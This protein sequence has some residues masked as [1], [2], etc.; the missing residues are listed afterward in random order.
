MRWYFGYPVL[1]AGL[2][3]GAHTLFPREIDDL[4]IRQADL[5][6]EPVEAPRV[7][8]AADVRREA[9]T[10]TRLAAFSP[11]A[12]LLE[13]ELPP[14]RPGMFDYLAQ[15]FAPGQP[16]PAV[17]LAAAVEPVASASWKSAVVHVA[18]T[19]TGT[20]TARTNTAAQRALLASDVQRELQR[21]GC[22]LGEIDGIWGPGSQRAVMAFME[23]VN[24]LLPVE[25]PDVFMLSLLKA[26]SNSVCGT[27][28]PQG[29]S[30]SAAGRCLP[31]TL[32]AHEDSSEPRLTRG[33]TLATRTQ[34][35]ALEPAGVHAAE[36]DWEATV[37]AEVPSPVGRRPPPLHGR[38]GIGGP[39]PDNALLPSSGRSHTAVMPIASRRLHRTASIEPSLP[40]DIAEDLTG[41]AAHPIEAAVPQRRVAEPVAAPRRQPK[42]RAAERPRPV[43][44]SRPKAWRSNYRQVQH[45]FQHPLGRM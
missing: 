11:G 12:R 29:Q 14:P 21:V 8:V 26:E 36:S 39:K 44:S 19:D 16:E 10:P 15:R 13:A 23:R 27:T 3:F 41:E 30:L 45:L 6:A 17:A 38:M 40:A 37:I 33:P 9:E 18:A 42:A 32:L 35:D 24:A 28:C 22:Y 1:A 25:E 5:P 7:V 4:M 34:R 20:K 2:F 31:T 43:K